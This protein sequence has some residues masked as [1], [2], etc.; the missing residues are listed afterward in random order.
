MLYIKLND[1]GSIKEYPYAKDLFEK[2]NLQELFYEKFNE[3]NIS[4]FN[5]ISHLNLLRFIDE[6]VYVGIPHYINL[7]QSYN[8]YVVEN[9][10]IPEI[11]FTQGI[12]E[13]NPIKLSNKWKQQWEVYD[14]SKEEIDIKNDKQAKIVRKQRDNL[15]LE[16]DW[17]IIKSIETG[18]PKNDKWVQY[19]QDLRNLPDQEG[20]PW[21]VVW[22]TQP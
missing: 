9:T 5:R 2:N 6:P 7:L 4:N 21:N 11:F 12:R 10:P 22:P 14:L 20:F 3:I 13:L 1:D 15:L 17:H 16:T 18:I 19:R 8:V